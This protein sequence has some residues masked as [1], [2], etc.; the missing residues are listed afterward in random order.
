[1]QAEVRPGGGYQI[2]S[3]NTASALFMVAFDIM[4]EWIKPFDP[5]DITYASLDR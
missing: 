2:P 3:K 1:M 4:F 5:M